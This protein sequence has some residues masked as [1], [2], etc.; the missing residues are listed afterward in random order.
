MQA[1]LALEQSALGLPEWVTELM[2]ADEPTLRRVY[3]TAVTELARFANVDEN[4]A[5]KNASFPA[6]EIEP[7]P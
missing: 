5:D 7:L 1:G 4:E 3:E 6:V 2:T